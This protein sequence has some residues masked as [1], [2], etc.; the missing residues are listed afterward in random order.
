MSSS[1]IV[2]AFLN[3]GQGDSTVIILPDQKSAHVIDCPH[4]KAPV[5]LAYLEDHGVQTLDVIF[6]THTDLDHIGGIPRLIEDFPDVI[7]VAWNIDRSNITNVKRKKILQHLLVLHRE[8]GI[9]RFEPRAERED[10]TI[11][12]RQ[13]VLMEVLYPTS[14]ELDLSRLASDA[15]NASVVLML[16]FADKKVL[17]P[18]DLMMLGWQRVIQRDVDLAANIFK[19]PHHGSWYDSE[20]YSLEDVLDKVLP[21]Y[22]VIS[23]GTNNQYMHPR[24]ETVDLLRKRGVQI[25]CTQATSRCWKNLPNDTQAHPCAGNVEIFLSHDRSEIATEFDPPS[26]CGFPFETSFS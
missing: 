22:V 8:R 2:V 16:L 26:D 7:S 9:K 18:G 13:S 23:A 19:F 3:V 11:F 4:N 24:S 14:N 1:Q 15:N 25:L 6:V 17:F 10:T 21:K 12:E 20:K 5:T